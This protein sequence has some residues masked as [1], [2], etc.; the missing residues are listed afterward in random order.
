[1][2]TKIVPFDLETMD[3]AIS[4]KTTDG[5]VVTQVIYF[6]SATNESY[7]IL[8]EI[9]NYIHRFTLEGRHEA[10][11]SVKLLMEVGV[12]DDVEDEMDGWEVWQKLK[13]CPELI[14]QLD[15]SKMNE[16][17]LRRLL[18]VQPQLIDQLDISKMDG[19][20]IGELLRK[21]PQLINRVGIYKMDDG[22]I[23]TLLQ[24]QPQ[25][26]EYFNK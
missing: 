1:M 6:A 24:N 23:Y 17:D 21:Q 9:F 20:Q 3:Q 22:D 2:N 11:R 8:G 26:A 10:N 25:L 12:E 5:Q 18:Q 15:I 16:W 4:F 13:M 19:F 7:Q 14:D